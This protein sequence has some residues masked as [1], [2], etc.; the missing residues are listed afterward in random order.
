MRAVTIAF[1]ISAL[2]VFLTL[3]ILRDDR[4]ASPEA[5]RAGSRLNQ[6][7][8]S[9][10]RHELSSQQTVAPAIR[11]TDISANA[12]KT[13][14]ASQLLAAPQPDEVRQ[15]MLSN[16]QLT[17]TSLLAFAEGLAP[18]VH[19]SKSSRASALQ[20]LS[21]VEQCLAQSSNQSATSLRA[22]CLEKALTLRDQYID[23]ASRVSSL[24]LRESPQVRDIAEKIK[25][26]ESKF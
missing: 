7:E 16:P 6:V 14:E 25:K 4:S 11:P 24:E 19:A 8:Q 2:A 20:L 26:A 21:L 13:S 12:T 9:G 3:K 5:N 1:F 15:E 23:L 22:F 18:L 10:E 17:P